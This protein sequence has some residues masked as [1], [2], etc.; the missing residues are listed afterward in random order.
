MPAPHTSPFSTTVPNK[1]V[2]HDEVQPMYPALYQFFGCYFHEDWCE[3]V[4]AP[5]ERLIGGQEP[6]PD[7]FKRAVRAYAGGCSR[8][9]GAKV[10]GELEQLLEQPLSD[11]DLALL[12]ARDL[13]VCYWPG[14]DEAY[15]PWL[16][17]V[18]AALEASLR[19]AA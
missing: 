15:R 14:S 18:R 10:L 13:G 17:E 6:E 4:T 8:E 1:P 7:V 2:A 16:Q 19:S 3:D 12:L 11:T 9:E 5:E